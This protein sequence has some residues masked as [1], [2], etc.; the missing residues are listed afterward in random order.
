[1]ITYK[2]VSTNGNGNKLVRTAKMTDHGQMPIYTEREALG[3]IAQIKTS[4]A[5]LPEWGRER[6]FRIESIEW[7]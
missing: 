7:A 2:I 3:I 6:D 5:C 1:M 4:Q